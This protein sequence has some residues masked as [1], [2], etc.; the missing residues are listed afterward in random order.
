MTADATG[1]IFL[2]GKFW[3]TIDFG[4]GNLTSAGIGDIFLAKLDDRGRHLWSHAFGGIAPDAG[5]SVSI[6]DQGAVVW[7]GYTKN[8][9]DLGGGMLGSPDDYDILLATFTSGG[10]HLWS[11]RLGGTAWDEVNQ[12]IV[13]PAGNILLTGFFEDVT[14]LGGSTLS[15]GGGRTAFLAKYEDV[16]IG[17]P[18]PDPAAISGLTLHPVS[19]NPS[20]LGAATWLEVDAATSARVGIFD[21][22]GRQ[23]RALVD[24]IFPA[25]I[26]PVT[27]DGRDEQGSRA[28]AGV[29]FLRTTWADGTASRKIVLAR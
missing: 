24:R 26:H 8:D 9:V 23:V 19:P 5:V 7:S 20:R 13:D 18:S 21:V 29:Y 15:V 25:G 16:I 22:N 12:S 28:P 4:G 3:N 14:N 27:W 1:A 6:A 17:V 2:T 10:G 11:T